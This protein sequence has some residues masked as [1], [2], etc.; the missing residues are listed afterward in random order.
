MKKKKS[1]FDDIMAGGIPGIPEAGVPRG[2]GQPPEG[3]GE[4][5]FMKAFK[6]AKKK[7]KKKGRR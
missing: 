5:G 7:T 6:N 4:G 2:G 3:R 1:P